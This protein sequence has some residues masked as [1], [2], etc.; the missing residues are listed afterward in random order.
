MDTLFK[1][2]MNELNNKDNEADSRNYKECSW[3]RVYSIRIG[4]Y[5]LNLIIDK[6]EIE[7]F[8]QF[9]FIISTDY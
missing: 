5:F 1:P 2:V 3:K 9:Y 8:C 6:V 4:L 7:G